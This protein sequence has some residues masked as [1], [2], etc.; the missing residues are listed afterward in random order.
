MSDS[1]ITN[2]NFEKS[3]N[4]KKHNTELN[5]VID[6]NSKQKIES[7]SIIKVSLKSKQKIDSKSIIKINL[8]NSKGKV[9]APKVNVQSSYLET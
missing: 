2:N 6:E 1:K 8:K 4:S 5:N 7:K 9:R 3:N